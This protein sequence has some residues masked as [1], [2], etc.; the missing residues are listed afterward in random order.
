MPESLYLP[1]FGVFTHVSLQIVHQRRRVIVHVQDLHGHIHAG[2]LCGVIC[3]DTDT[4]SEQNKR[5]RS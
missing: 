5:R 4:N 1:R 3:R 2:D